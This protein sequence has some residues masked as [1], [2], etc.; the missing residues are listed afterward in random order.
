M[1][2]LRVY[3]EGLAVMISDSMMTVET[4]CWCGKQ[5]DVTVLQSEYDAWRAGGLIQNVMPSLPAN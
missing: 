2:L 5:Q 4:V 3:L 1:G